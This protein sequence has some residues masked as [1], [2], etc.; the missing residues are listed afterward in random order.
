[1]NLRIFTGYMPADAQQAFVPATADA[2]ALRKLVFDVVIKDSRGV[3]FPEKCMVDDPELIAKYESLLTSGRM[4]VCEGEQTAYPF[5]ERGVLK[6]YTRK[7]RM[8]RMEFPNRS[9]K[10]TT[11]E[12]TE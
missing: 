5:H 4:V 3:E 8:H 6:G 12:K 7:V 9:T 2:P 10:K 11:E 1:M